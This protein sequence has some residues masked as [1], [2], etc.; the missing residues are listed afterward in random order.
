M[1]SKKEVNEIA[2]EASLAEEARAMAMILA[3]NGTL[4]NRK[5]PRTSEWR[6]DGEEND[7]PKVGWLFIKFSKFFFIKELD[8]SGQQNASMDTLILIEQAAKAASSS[9]GNGLP[10][11]RWT[12]ETSHSLMDISMKPY[13]YEVGL[14]DSSNVPDRPELLHNGTAIESGTG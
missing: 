7:P 2:D 14:Q 9:R 12:R 1:N 6:G 13:G 8:L 5:K 10:R 11:S 3:G 4:P